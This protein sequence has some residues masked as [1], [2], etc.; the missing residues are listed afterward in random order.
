[1]LKVLDIGC[2][3]VTKPLPF[4]TYADKRDY[5]E[6]IDIQN[7]EKLTYDWDCFDLVICINAL[8]HTPDVEAALHEIVRVSKNWVYIDCALI[9]KT[10]S[11][12]GHYWDMLEDGTMTNGTDSIDLKDYGFEIELIDNKM[13]RRYNH[14]VAKLKKYV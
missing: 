8:D 1:M 10:T 6:H 12:K 14:I 11:G 9:Q 7:M 5:N 2:G 13:E 3:P 4:I